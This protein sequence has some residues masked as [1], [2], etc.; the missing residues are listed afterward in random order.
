MKRDQL[1][2]VQKKLRQQYHQV[3]SWRKVAREYD[4][5]G[6]VLS[7]AM[8]RMVALGYEPKRSDIRRALGLPIYVA[9]QVC[10]RCGQV[11]P[12][13]RRHVSSN[14]MLLKFIRETA[15]SFLAAHDHVNSER[16]CPR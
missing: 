8:I 12:P 10:P 6:N 11:H 15:V 3:K 14:P 13:R 2:R 9:V 4:K 1:K 7:G 16:Q 5:S